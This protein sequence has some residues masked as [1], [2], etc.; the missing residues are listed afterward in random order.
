[1][2]IN[3]NYFDNKHIKLIKAGKITIVLFALKISHL[4]IV[5]EETDRSMEMKAM[6]NDI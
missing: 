6:F 2:L 5:L 4:I 3:V 1:M